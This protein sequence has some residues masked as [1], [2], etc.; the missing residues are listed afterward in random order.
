MAKETAAEKSAREEREKLV[1]ALM[2]KEVRELAERI[3]NL[4]DAGYKQV[5][6]YNQRIQ[7]LEDQVKQIKSDRRDLEIKFEGFK[8]G[9]RASSGSM[10]RFSG[11]G[12]MGPYPW[13]FG[14]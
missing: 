14:R 1:E 10:D 4:E 8:E 11:P 12:P 13:F 9:V 2:K 3:L 7:A 5:E 6:K